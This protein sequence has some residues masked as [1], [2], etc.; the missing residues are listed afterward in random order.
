MLRFAKHIAYGGRIFELDE[1]KSSRS[2]GLQVGHDDH[3]DDFS[4]ILKIVT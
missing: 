1:A 2:A 3:I 4:E